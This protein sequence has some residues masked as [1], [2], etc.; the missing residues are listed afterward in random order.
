MD[1]KNGNPNGDTPDG[2]PPVSPGKDFQL[3]DSPLPT[4]SRLSIAAETRHYPP[5]ESQ[6]TSPDSQQPS[7][8]GSPAATRSTHQPRLATPEGTYHQ[9]HNTHSG[10]SVQAQIVMGSVN[11]YNSGNTRGDKKND[12]DV[13]GKNNDDEMRERSGDEK[14]A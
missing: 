11:I 14:T 12:K 13:G 4:S 5:I 1:S 8:H 2:R 10:G 3:F 6:Q 7:A 9:D